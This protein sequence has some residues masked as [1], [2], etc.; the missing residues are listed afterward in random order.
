MTANYGK[1]AV[2]PQS[3]FFFVLYILMLIFFR[4]R[5]L[6]VGKEPQ[7]SKSAVAA[8]AGGEGGGAKTRH[9]SSPTE[10]VFFCTSF[11]VILIFLD[12]VMSML[13]KDRKSVV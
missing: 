9:V 3:M 11:T 2:A 4:L 1:P 13:D 7:R 5:Y 6:Y 8:G 12:Y 10:Y